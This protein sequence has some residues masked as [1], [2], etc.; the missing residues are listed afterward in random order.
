MVLGVEHS[1]LHVKLALSPLSHILVLYFK[2]NKAQ[3]DTCLVNFTDSYDFDV[4]FTV[5]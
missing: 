3:Q 2:E 4:F 5:C 1:L